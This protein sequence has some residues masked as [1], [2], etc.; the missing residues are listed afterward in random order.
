MDEKTFNII[1]INQ[2]GKRIIVV[3]GVTSY[4]ADTICRE[5]NKASRVCNRHNIRKYVSEQSM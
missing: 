1:K 3:R 2:N 5:Y 4:V